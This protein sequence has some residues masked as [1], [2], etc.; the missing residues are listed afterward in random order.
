MRKTRGNHRTE[1]IF[2]RNSKKIAQIWVLGFQ[3]PQVEE[4]HQIPLCPILCIDP[5]QCLLMFSVSYIF[6]YINKFLL[7]YLCGKSES[8]PLPN[9]RLRILLLV[10]LFP[11]KWETMLFPG[12]LSWN[13][14]LCSPVN[15]IFSH[16]HAVPLTQ[17]E[18]CVFGFSKTRK[19]AYLPSASA[20]P[21]QMPKSSTGDDP[22][23][24]RVD[25]K[26]KCQHGFSIKVNLPW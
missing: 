26:T 21:H 18:V 16:L 20:K 5:C 4:L 12:K 15:V 13:D 10:S 2:Q 19:D 17:L 24:F 23:K 25:C 7:Q 8:F 14:T 9:I 11:Q 6:I 22:P 3:S 1:T